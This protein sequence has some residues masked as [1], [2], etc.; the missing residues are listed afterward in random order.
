MGEWKIIVKSGVIVV[1]IWGVMVFADGLSE[2]EPV[3]SVIG[4]SSLLVA[5]NLWKA[6]VFS[7]EIR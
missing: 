3:P 7:Q 5:F 6:M 2:G 1:F 4:F